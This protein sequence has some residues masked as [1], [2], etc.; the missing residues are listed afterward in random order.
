MRKFLYFSI[1]GSILIFG[2]FI[3][4]K[5]LIEQTNLY[6]NG[7][8]LD[9]KI[10]EINKISSGRGVFNNN[11]QFI[12]LYEYNNEKYTKNVSVNSFINKHYVGERLKIYYNI[13]NGIIYP[14]KYIVK[15]ITI[16]IICLILIFLAIIFI[17]KA[18]NKKIIF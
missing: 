17:Y 12:I 7:I 10:I 8:K 5:N 9:S 13:K 14:S 2:I 15:D 11:L 3:I 16:S 4:G 1:T 6:Y 18:I